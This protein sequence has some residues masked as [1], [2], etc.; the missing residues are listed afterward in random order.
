[1]FLGLGTTPTSSFA[2]LSICEGA[3]YALYFQDN[4][5]VSPRLTLNLGLR[6]EYWPA[7][8]EK[9][10]ILTTFDPDK[11]GHHSWKR[12]Q[13]H[14]RSGRDRSVDRR[15][16]RGA[17]REVHDVRAGRQIAEPYA[18]P[19]EQFWAASR[20]C[21][22]AGQRV[23]VV[24]DARRL[25]DQLL[26]DPAAS[27]DRANA[28]ERSADDALPYIRDRCRAVAGRHRQLRHALVPTTWL[29]A[30]TAATR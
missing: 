12:S 15:T 23:E 28:L 27:V 9:N 26:P 30:S 6:W 18:E 17:G 2:V 19:E 1:M 10:N 20:F 3:R 11:Q 16:D 21:L 13:Y 4:F 22:P 25:P 8:R 7:F 14:V 24:R 29:R 5:K